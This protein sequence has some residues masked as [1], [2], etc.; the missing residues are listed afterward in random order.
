MEI[1]EITSNLNQDM[2]S[3]S[4]VSTLILPLIF[5]FNEVSSRSPMVEA[6]RRAG[7]PEVAFALP[8]SIDNACLNF[9]GK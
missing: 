9:S 8:E 4:G 7:F 2:F 5:G 6:F 1:K 3:T